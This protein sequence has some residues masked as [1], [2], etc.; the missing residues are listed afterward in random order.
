MISDKRFWSEKITQSIFI[1]SAVISV[2]LFFISCVN[3]DFQEEFKIIISEPSEVRA[4]SIQI[5]GAIVDVANFKS[6]F[7][8]GLCWSLNNSP[9]LSS[10]S[11]KCGSENKPVQFSNRLL[12]L[13]PNTK[14]FIRSYAS[15]G[16]NVFYSD[17]LNF[18]TKDITL[19]TIENSKVDSISLNT[20]IAKFSITNT[21]YDVDSVL[22]CGFCWS[23]TESPTLSNSYNDLGI[24][25]KPAIIRSKIELLQ[26]GAT[27]YIRSYAKNK[28]GLSYGENVKFRT[29]SMKPIVEIDSIGSIGFSNVN[30][31]GKIIDLGYSS[32]FV[33]AYGSCYSIDNIS[34]S[35]LNSKVELANKS[36]TGTFMTSV[37]NLQQNK[38]YYVNAFA[39]NAYGLGYSTVKSFKTLG[40]YLLNVTCNGNFGWNVSPSYSI[41][42]PGAMGICWSE[43]NTYFDQTWGPFNKGTGQLYFFYTRSCANSGA[44]NVYLIDGTDVTKKGT[45]AISNTQIYGTILCKINPPSSFCIRVTANGDLAIRSFG[46]VR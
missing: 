2:S 15:D 8:Y 41:T 28:K 34:P 43:G 35:Y 19:A 11:L 7:E 25:T 9:T 17:L 46:L 3:R 4:K 18:T 36:E 40:D 37:S 13:I 22:S 45:L 20:C 24:Q 5:S 39:K 44:F 27:Y 42:A 23:L 29:R 32:S 16:N 26:E 21:G 10:N 31:Y 12:N 38:T 33:E 30:V 6:S 1:F 14:Y